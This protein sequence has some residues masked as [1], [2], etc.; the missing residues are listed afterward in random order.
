[1]DTSCHEQFMKSSEESGQ[2]PLPV[3]I[4]ELIQSWAMSVSCSFHRSFS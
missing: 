3:V 4:E 1:M 2:N